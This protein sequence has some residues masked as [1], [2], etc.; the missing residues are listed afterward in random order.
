MNDAREERRA[1]LEPLVTTRRLVSYLRQSRPGSDDSSST[2]KC[3]TSVNFELQTR[4]QVE[5]K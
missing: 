1:P 5:A 4:E 2:T 3:M